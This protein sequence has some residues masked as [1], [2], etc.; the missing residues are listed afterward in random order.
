VV[1]VGELSEVTLK[2]MWLAYFEFRQ[3]SP[4][5]SKTK[6]FPGQMSLPWDKQRVTESTEVRE[7]SEKFI[8]ANC[9]QPPVS[10]IRWAEC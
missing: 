5:E 7:V 1:G 8:R 3:I 6:K 9:Y 4:C 10:G 2:S